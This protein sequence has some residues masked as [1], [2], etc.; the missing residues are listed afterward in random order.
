VTRIPR[1]A[2]LCALAA[3]ALATATSAVAFEARAGIAF[4]AVTGSSEGSELV[5]ED[6]NGNEV[7]RGTA[8]RFGSLVFRELEQGGA[9]VVRDAGSGGAAVP[10]TVLRFDDHPDASFYEGQTLVD[11]Y[12]Y[13]RTRDGTLLAAMVRPPLGKTLA[14]G[15]FP[16]V[17]EYSGYAAADPNATQPSTLLSSALG[18]ATVAVNM[19]GQE[20]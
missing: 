15:P 17:V 8:D 6:A 3:A 18:Y 19:R 10:V 14:Q 2:L 5:L 13:I 11:G 20:G 12:Q 9:Y 1:F 7:E 4:V 16:T